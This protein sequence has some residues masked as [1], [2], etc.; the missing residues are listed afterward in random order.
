MD[1]SKNMKLQIVSTLKEKAVA[2]QIA[3]DETEEAF[4]VLKQILAEITEEYNKDLEGADKRIMMEFIDRGAFEAELKVAGDLLIFNMHSNIFKFDYGHPIWR[5][6]EAK[7]EP[8][9]SYSGII[10]IFNFIADSF[11]Y[12]RLDDLGYLIGRI[13]INMEGDF[14]V[15][16][17]RELGF[18]FPAFGRNHVNYH[19]MKKLVESAI[20]YI[21]KFDI[22]VPPYED[23]KII[24]VDTMKQK[25][26]SSKIKT[27]K[28]LGFAYNVDLDRATE[29]DD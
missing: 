28:R 25:I 4:K 20:S 6:S 13:F 19:N 24:S 2:K 16:G 22:L 1:D 5:N 3:Y 11:K 17:R 18:F 10:S 12:D 23:V 9:K 8:I 15:E 7:E 21:L 14:F 26:N 27:A 29:L